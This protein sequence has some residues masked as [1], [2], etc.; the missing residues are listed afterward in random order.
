MR[1][2]EVPKWV[3]SL[4]NEELNFIKQFILKSGSFKDMAKTYKIPYPT[5]RNQ[6]DKLIEK[7]EMNSKT[8]SDSLIDV[9]KDL[10]LKNRISIE[11]AS[12]I[13]NKIKE[14]KLKR[15]HVD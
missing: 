3:L 2:D 4:N 8:D 10:T 6:T 11:D 14:D 5:L 9:I 13:I 1:N 12:M 7:I 15:D